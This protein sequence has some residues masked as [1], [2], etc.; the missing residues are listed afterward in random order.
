MNIMTHGSST[1]VKINVQGSDK[2]ERRYVELLGGL[3]NV[4]A[5]FNVDIRGFD[6]GLVHH[7]IKPARQNQGLVNSAL[8]GTFQR[9]LRDFLRTEMFLV[10]P[11]WVSNW[12]PAS[13]TTNNIRNCISLRNF[14]QE[15]MRNPFPPLCMEMFLQQVV[16]SQLEPLFDSLFGYDKI[17]IEGENIHKTTFIISWGTMSYNFLPSSLFDASIPLKGPMHTT[18][19]ELVSLHAYLDDLIVCEKRLII[20]HNFKCWSI[21][22]L[23]LSW[24]LTQKSS[25]NYRDNGFPTT[26]TV[27]A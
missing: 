12:E 5:L 7:T 20:H 26:L 25:R 14:M 8:G 6:P 23:L 19:D 24:T 27:L 16:E 1:N 18:F 22:R 3:Q 15:I 2:E 4:C 9:E 21:S 11:E 13:K 10:H 17:K